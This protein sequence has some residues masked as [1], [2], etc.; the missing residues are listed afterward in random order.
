MDSNLNEVRSLCNFDEKIPE[1]SGTQRTFT[2]YAHDSY[3]KRMPEGADAQLAQF[4]QGKSKTMYMVRYGTN[5]T[6]SYIAEHFSNVSTIKNDLTNLKGYM[7]NRMALDITHRFSF[8]TATSYTDMDGETVDTT[9]GGG[10]LAWVYATQTLNGSSI[11]LSNVITSNPRFSK[12]AFEVAK[13]VAKAASLDEFGVPIEID[14][15]T[16]YSA[17]EATT[18][19]SILSLLRSTADPTTNNA[20]VVNNYKGQFRHVILKKLDT[21]AQGAYDTTKQYY[22]GYYAAGKGSKYATLNL[23]VWETPHGVAE[24]V[25]IQNDEKTLGSRAAWGLCVVDHRG[26]VH[27]TGTGA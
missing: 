15:N 8:C 12:G 22:W 6:V 21:D 3:G 2:S 16:V 23:G 17:N 19:D 25:N 26:N 11:T 1:K 18:V 4:V 5:A 9:I 13:N 24:D 27:S 20:G 14:F 7:P 10:T